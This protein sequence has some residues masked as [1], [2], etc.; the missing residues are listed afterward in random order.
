MFVYLLLKSAC[1]HSLLCVFVCG[2]VAGWVGVQLI[3]MQV[4]NRNMIYPRPEPKS[5]Q[6]PRQSQSKQ[7][8]MA[9]SVS[10][11]VE[12]DEARGRGRLHDWQPKRSMGIGVSNGVTG[13]PSPAPSPRTLSSHPVSCCSLPHKLSK[14]YAS[15]D[16][17][18]SNCC[19]PPRCCS[20]KAFGM[21]TSNMVCRSPVTDFA[22]Q[23]QLD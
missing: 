8:P 6:N 3:N 23:R 14:N 1:L 17:T 15:F 12:E 20:V 2:C 13:T 10:A 11:Q 16:L 18:Q 7:P 19:C 4:I 21:L 5:H 22:F 9:L